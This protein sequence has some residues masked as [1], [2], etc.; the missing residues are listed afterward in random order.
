MLEIPSP[1]VL[2][3]PCRTAS[4][5]Q[6]FHL[7]SQAAPLLWSLRGDVL[8]SHQGGSCRDRAGGLHPL[9][10]RLP[11]SDQPGNLGLQVSGNPSCSLTFMLLTSMGHPE[12]ALGPAVLLFCV[13][14]NMKRGSGQGH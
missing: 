5:V 12:P 6:S 9:W 13:L 4:L 3:H 1:P 14:S 7:K 8:E 11:A 10:V 2:G